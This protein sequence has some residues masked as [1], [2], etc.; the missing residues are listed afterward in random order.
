MSGTKCRMHL[1][2]PPPL[3]R[4]HLEVDT[5]LLI[6]VCVVTLR[7]KEEISGELGVSE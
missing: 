5:N 3:T 7:H 1:N 2:P 6:L 4:I